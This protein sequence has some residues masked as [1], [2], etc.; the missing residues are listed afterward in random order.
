M[1]DEV[2]FYVVDLG[3]DLLKGLG[4]HAVA[5]LVPL[6]I[7]F[8]LARAGHVRTAWRLP[9]GIFVL[10]LAFVV[11]GVMLAQDVQT[12]PGVVLSIALMSVPAILGGVLGTLLG[13]R[14]T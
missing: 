4:V 12:A 2:T 13:R 9:A 10:T 1:Q 14:R 5:F 11:L 8:G 3:Q 7:S 6:T